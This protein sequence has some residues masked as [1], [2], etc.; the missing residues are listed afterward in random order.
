MDPVKARSRL[1]QSRVRLAKTGSLCERP[2][3]VTSTQL[4]HLTRLQPSLLLTDS[5]ICSDKLSAAAEICL[6]ADFR[7]RPPLVGTHDKFVLC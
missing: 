5:R 4:P 1:E 2:G 7:Q 6:D 3:L